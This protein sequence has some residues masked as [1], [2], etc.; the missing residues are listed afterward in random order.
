MKIKQYLVWVIGFSLVLFSCKKEHYSNNSTST[1]AVFYFN[2]TV[3]GISTNLRAG[4]NHYYMFSS[5]LADGN[6]VYDFI[7]EF[8]DE[9]CT[10]NCANSIA[11]KVKDYRPWATNHTTIDSSIIAGY[12]T[13]ATPAGGHASYNLTFGGGPGNGIGHTW[14]WNY[15]D[16]TSSSGT[17]STTVHQYLHPGIYN[18]SLNIITT[19]SCSSTIA[20][21]IIVGQVGNAFM[22]TFSPVVNLFYAKFNAVPNGVPPYTYNWDFGDSH[23]STAASPTYTYASPGIYLTTLNMTDSS[24]YTSIQHQHTIIHDSTCGT[25]FSIS[26]MTPIANPINLADVIIEWHDAAGALW[27]S[28]N[29]SQSSKSLFQVLSVEK[30]IN[31][32]KGQPTKRVHAKISCTLYNGTNSMPFSGEAVFAVAHL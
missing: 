15:G 4:F 22:A 18:V 25:H 23:A 24:G 6:G 13:F 11:I 28:Q 16:G 12:Y 14:N 7:G 17:S 30:Y 31:N 20:N 21:D 32:S 9:T 5:C 8:K 3:N 19:S 1:P 2:G 27:T 10:A 26:N 29:N